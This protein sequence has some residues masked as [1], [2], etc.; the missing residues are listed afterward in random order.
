MSEANAE[1]ATKPSAYERIG[2]AAGLR[3]LTKRFYELMDELPEA[4]ACRAIHQES[5]A[6]AEQ[7]LFEYLSFWLG[8]PPLFTERHGAPMLRARH[9][10]VPI[11]ND[12]TVGWLVCFHRAWTETVDDPDLGKEILPSVNS[13]ALAMRNKEG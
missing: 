5:L 9:L 6:G 11:G 7:M 2:G 13:L 1:T 4:A 8:G 10:H 12:E 3:R